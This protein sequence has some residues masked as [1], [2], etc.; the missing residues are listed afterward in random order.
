MNKDK[1]VP[2]PSAGFLACI[3]ALSTHLYLDSRISVITKI[4][5]FSQK[6]KLIVKLNESEQKIV[7]RMKIKSKHF[8]LSMK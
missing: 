3:I 4:S 6:I 7:L 5:F 8:K 2:L 1:L